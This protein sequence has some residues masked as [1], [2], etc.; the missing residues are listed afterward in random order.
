MLQ[1]NCSSWQPCMYTHTHTHKHTYKHTPVHTKLFILSI[2]R[3]LVHDTSLHHISWGSQ[4]SCYKTWAYTAK[5]KHVHAHPFTH[6]HIYSFENWNVCTHINIITCTTTSEHTHS[7]NRY[8]AKRVCEVIWNV[9][10]FI[11][12]QCYKTTT[13][14]SVAHP[15]V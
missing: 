10:V 15:A 12:S 7:S 11:T 13:Q 3:W 5:H 14:V 4:Q 2:F 9:P 1:Q 6:T 8:W